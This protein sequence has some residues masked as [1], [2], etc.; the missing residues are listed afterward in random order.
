M[1]LR[2][3]FTERGQPSRDLLSADIQGDRVRFWVSPADKDRFSIGTIERSALMVA[4]DTATED[5]SLT[6]TAKGGFYIIRFK[7]FDTKYTWKMTINDV[8]ELAEALPE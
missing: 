5:G 7:G 1:D 4:E 3:L 6:L 8:Q 2:R